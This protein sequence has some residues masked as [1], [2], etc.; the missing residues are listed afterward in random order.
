MFV[1]LNVRSAYTLE[2]GVLKIETL[3][4]RAAAQGHRALA[5]TDRD[6]CYGLPAFQTA[7]DAV[8]VKPIH[9]VELTEP[10]AGLEHAHA[11]LLVKDA[12]GYRNLCRLVTAR[13]LDE[14]FALADALPRHAEGLVVLTSS[15][16]LLMHLAPELAPCG[17]T[18]A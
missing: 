8:D 9:G 12:R 18:S 1:H 14:R 7:C 13:A 11:V 10:T 6:A 15:P 16:R 3:V 4:A 17:R 5:L 2:G